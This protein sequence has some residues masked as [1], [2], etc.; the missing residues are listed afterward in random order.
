MLVDRDWLPSPTVWK[1]PGP[2]RHTIE[3]PLR[4]GWRLNID[5]PSDVGNNR[6]RVPARMEFLGPEDPSPRGT[7]PVKSFHFSPSLDAVYIAR[8]ARG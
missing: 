3:Y 1:N 6:E 2:V 4:D 5:Y 8:R 7:I